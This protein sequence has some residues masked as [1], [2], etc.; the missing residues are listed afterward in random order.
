MRIFQV[1]TVGYWPTYPSIA[2]SLPLEVAQQKQQFEAFY[3]VRYTGRRLAWVHYLDRVV[4]GA[5]FGKG[6][7]ELDMAL[8]QAVVLLCFNGQVAAPAPA[9]G[10]GD[11][12]RATQLD[13]PLLRA[14]LVA[15]CMV[16]PALRLLSKSIKSKEV[17]YMACVNS[18]T[19]L[20]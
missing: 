3:S 15:L 16:P 6:R 1:L 19:E 17:R 11:L 12:Q 14:C 5:Q 2:L 20:V 7:K 4:L 9:L 10:F 8:T 13:T 18:Y